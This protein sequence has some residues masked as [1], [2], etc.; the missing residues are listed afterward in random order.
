VNVDAR[1]TVN[2]PETVIENRV[3]PTPVNVEAP[4]VNVEAPV[5]HVDSPV[6]VEPTPVTVHNEAPVIN[7]EPTPVTV[8]SPV[9]NVEAPVIEN[10]TDLDPLLTEVKG[11]RADTKKQR[12]N[13]VVNVDE[14]TVKSL[15]ERVHRV[16]RDS[17][18]RAIGSTESDA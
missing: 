13:V 18:G 6:T 5:V 2:V 10:K 8:G 14:V 16:V 3:E 7:V 15:P 1:S 17:E 11:L 9:V 4:V 12:Q